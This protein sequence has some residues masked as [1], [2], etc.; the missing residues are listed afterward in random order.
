MTAICMFYE[1]LISLANKRECFEKTFNDNLQKMSTVK[2]PNSIQPP[3]FNLLSSNGD[4]QLFGKVS[5]LTCTYPTWPGS[6]RSCLNTLQFRMSLLCHIVGHSRS[7]K[8]EPFL[9]LKTA[10]AFRIFA[11]LW[12]WFFKI[13]ASLRI[14][15]FRIF[16]SLGI[17]FFR[18]FASLGIWFFRIFT[19]LGMWFFCC[20]FFLS[21]YS[22]LFLW[23]SLLWKLSMFS[24]KSIDCCS[25]L[26]SP[27]WCT[28]RLESYDQSV[29]I[30]RR[31]TLKGTMDCLQSTLHPARCH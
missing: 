2:P 12:I 23:S 11:S 14:W 31:M 21:C 17:W 16:A 30:R 10:E 9:L 18:I 20:S 4:R 25:L 3:D 5:M 27:A 8:Q 29:V 26:R 7:R 15:F 28:R 1:Q 22:H 24:R 6:L 13:F 19:N